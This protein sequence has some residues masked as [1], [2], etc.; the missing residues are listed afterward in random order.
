M[1]NFRSYAMLCGGGLSCSCTHSALALAWPWKGPA[2]ALRQVALLTSLP[3][4]KYM[5]YCF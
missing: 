5:A 4:I 2:F 3:I 1:F